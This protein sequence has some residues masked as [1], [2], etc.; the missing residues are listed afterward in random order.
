MLRKSTRSLIVAVA[1]ICGLFV[2]IAT[3]AQAASGGGCYDHPNT[4]PCISLS[5][6]FLY[7]DFYQNRTPDASMYRAVLT[8]I[9]KG[10]AVKS[11]TYYLTR[12]GRYGPISYNKA[13]LPIT[14]GS[15]YSRVQVYTN[16]GALH[17]TV[18]SPTLRY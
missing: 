4:D 13:T 16:T 5:G 12:T 2:A 18:Y 15:A 7:A 17:Y 14:S 3:P 6:N 9:N 10:K 8:I 11:A 1:M